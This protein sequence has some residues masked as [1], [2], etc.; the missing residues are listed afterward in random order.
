[1]GQDAVLGID[2]GTSSVRALL[3][4]GTGGVVASA[5]QT[6]SIQAPHPGW[7]E[8]DPEDWWQATCAAIAECQRSAP[9][10]AIRSVSFSGQMHGTVLVDQ[11]GNPL[12][13]AIIWC[14]QRSAAEVNG[15]LSAFGKERL[16]QITANPLATGFQLATLLWLR[17]HEPGTLRKV[18]TVLLPKDHLRGRMTGVW[19]TDPSDA[20][21]T[22][23]FNTA[24]RCWSPEIIDAAG[25]NG[26]WL[27]PVNEATDRAGE[28]GRRACEA[29]GIPVGT[30]VFTGGADLPLTA[31]GNGVI[32]PGQVLATIGSGG[33]LC[34]PMSEPNYDPKLRTHTFCHVVPGQWYVMG[35]I[36]SAGLSLHWLREQVLGPNAPDYAALS[37]EAATVPPGA[38]GLLFLPYL[39]GER[40]PHL[41]PYACGVFFGLTPRH[42]RAHLVRAVMEGVVFA[43]SEGLDIMRGLGITPRSVVAAGG[44]ARSRLWRQIQ[45]DVYHSTVM[46]TRTEEQAAFGAA[47]LAGVGI[48]WWPNVQYACKACVKPASEPIEPIE[49]HQEQYE[50]LRDLYRRL[51]PRLR[52]LMAERSRLVVRGGRES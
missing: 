3:L 48:E 12:R 9:Q 1:M 19:G 21:S 45:A 13:P 37:D 31:L 35:A 29:T 8:Q 28:I 42:T 18:S 44:G 26:S 34:A 47:L 5:A 6:Y 49:E 24:C 38:E 52:E 36:L 4:D 16:A 22:L 14:D 17:E 25:L 43:L 23:A 51:Y 41:D 33:Q 10:A 40:T 46:T 50:A 27:P 15:F 32:E 30:R 2:L 39:T 7:A 20:C 11:D